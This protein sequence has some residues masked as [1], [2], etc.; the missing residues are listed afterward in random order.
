MVRDTDPRSFAPRAFLRIA[1]TEAAAFQLEFERNLSKGGLFAPTGDA[2]EPRA[3]VDVQ[4]ALEF[5]GETVVLPAEVVALRPADPQRG[6]EAGV[7]LQILE[8]ASDL[9]ERFR[10]FL[11]PPAP[12]RDPARGAERRAVPRAPAQVAVR[13]SADAERAAART[14]DLSATGALLEV[15]GAA[16]EVG[17]TVDVALVH[18]TRGDEQHVV[19]TVVR[20]DGVSEDGRAR[21]AVRFDPAPG[22]STHVRRIVED[23]QAA[24]H[25]RRLGAIAGPIAELGVPS[26]LQM[27]AMSA[28]RGT[29]IL[30]REGEEAS[31]GF[32]GGMLRFARAGG[33]IGLKAL[34]RL[35]GWREGRFEFRVGFDEPAA[36]EPPLPLDAALLEAVRQGDELARCASAKLPPTTR[37]RVVR[38]GLEQHG[39][40][41]GKTEQAVVDLVGAGFALGRLLD[42]IPETDAEIHAAVSSLLERGVLVPAS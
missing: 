5:C 26:L 18:P 28:P 40:A 7:A 31:V 35:L 6:V 14:R 29:L 2:F 16:P 1:F 13:L 22:Q 10:R 3:L 11:P 20:H 21:V 38:A 25:A 9:R 32:D 15:H 23:V 12:P 30:T 19:G 4:I 37:L 42:V 41:L 39:S 33:A 17:E 36:E 8:P 27:F 34:G 24:D